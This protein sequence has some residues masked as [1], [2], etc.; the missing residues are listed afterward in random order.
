MGLQ[1][2]SSTFSAE[3]ILIFEH[4]PSG[5]GGLVLN[6]PTPIKLRDLGIPKFVEFAENSVLLGCGT[7]KAPQSLNSNIPLADM[8]PWFWIHNVVGL[9][10]SSVLPGANGTLFMGGSIDQASDMIREGSVRPS[11][12]KFFWKYKSWVGDDLL[13]EI[14]AGHWIC[15]P[16][17]PVEALSC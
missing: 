13:K 5:T 17:D 4:T 1:P 3:R 16:I 2:I 14:E 9:Q 11:Q 8:A 15:H 10:G 6:Q 7:T 12:F